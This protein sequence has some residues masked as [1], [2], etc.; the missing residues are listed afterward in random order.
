M[1]V[2]P[3]STRGSGSIALLAVTGH[4]RQRSQRN[5][6]GL[7][8]M[9][10]VIQYILQLFNNEVA[11]QEFAANPE[12]AL[13]NAGLS[14]VTSEQ[15]QS[16]ASA[17]VPGLSLGDGNPV[18]GLQQAVSDQFGFAGNEGVGLESGGGFG[19]AATKGIKALATSAGVW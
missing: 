16:A 5:A 1:G 18:A 10:S 12:A 17:A 3:L 15:L 19:G 11:A 14:G 4:I 6:K 2:V 13:A 9:D 7:S 8:V